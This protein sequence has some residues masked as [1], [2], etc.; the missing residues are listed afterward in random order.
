MS[1]TNV[2]LSGIA[3][4]VSFNRLVNNGNSGRQSKQ[5]V[6]GVRP[7]LSASENGYI[8]VRDRVLREKGRIDRFPCQMLLSNQKFQFS[9]TP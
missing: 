7:V 1:G 5:E 2:H 6:L 9:R 3:Y 8:G 4:Q